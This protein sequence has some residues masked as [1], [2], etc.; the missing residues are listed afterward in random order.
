M[1]APR[2]RTSR[3]SR[4]SNGASG[5]ATL[6]DV[7]ELAGVDQSTASR[8]LR[9]DPAQAVRPETRERI[10][11]AAQELRYRPNA[12]A[13]SLRTRTTQTLGFVVPDLENIG[14]TAVARGVQTAASAAGYL[15]LLAEA[16]ETEGPEL[17]ERLATERRIDGLLVANAG[18][19]VTADGPPGIPVVY[20]N[21]RVPGAQASV[22]VDDQRGG[23]LAIEYLLS[24]GHRRIAYVA[25]PPNTDTGRRRRRGVVRALKAVGL[26]LDPRWEAS[27]G[28]TDRGGAE[29]AATILRRSGRDRPTAVFAANLVS[30]LG[31]LRTFTDAGLRVPQDISLITMDDHPLAIYT[32]PPLTTIAMPLSEMGSHAAQMLI[33]AIRGEPLRHEMV[34]TP[35]AVIVRGSTAPPAGQRRAR[36]ELAKR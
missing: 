25:G 5:S 2:T 21:R 17:Y 27:G 33:G 3:P 30:A 14:F 31:A 13:A 28:F 26:E 19:D 10:L 4:R 12:I 35:P 9:D 11:A 8:V 23:E 34:S 7:A 24:L 16:S 36:G 1:A 29:A 15:V 6:R 32:A 18:L 22:I 20:V